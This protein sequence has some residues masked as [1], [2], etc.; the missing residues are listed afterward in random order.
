[1]LFFKYQQ[2]V[3]GQLITD[4]CNSRAPICRVL[5]HFK[6]A[7]QCNS[8]GNNN[9]GHVPRDNKHH[10]YTK[11]KSTK[12]A[13]DVYHP[14]PGRMNISGSI[15]LFFFI[16]FRFNSLF[17]SISMKKKKNNLSLSHAKIKMVFEAF[18]CFFYLQFGEWS[19]E[20]RQP[21]KIDL[22]QILWGKNNKNVSFFLSGNATAFCFFFFFCSFICLCGFYGRWA[23][24]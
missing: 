14:P 13:Q 4:S 17:F 9:E 5:N 1:M 21:K 24:A 11:K 10:H 23:I 18:C 2:I 8:T 12:R 20:R 6:I 19:T 15:F 3:N 7:T 16:L 22:V